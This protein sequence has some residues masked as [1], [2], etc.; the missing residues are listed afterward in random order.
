MDMNGKY[1]LVYLWNV[2]SLSNQMDLSYKKICF[3]DWFVTYLIRL[4]HNAF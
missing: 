1:V 4:M 2:L 3:T